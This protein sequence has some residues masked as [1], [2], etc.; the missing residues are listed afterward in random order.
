MINVL[1]TAGKTIFIL[2]DI[3]LSSI[4]HKAM[5]HKTWRATLAFQ[6]LFP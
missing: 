2:P 5:L 4:E 3:A 1:S 6:P